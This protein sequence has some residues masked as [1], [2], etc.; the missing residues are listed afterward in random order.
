MEILIKYAIDSWPGPSKLL[1]LLFLAILTIVLPIGILLW[2]K[3]FIDRD[4]YIFQQSAN[5]LYC[6]DSMTGQ[7]LVA[8]GL[9]FQK[10]YIMEA[11]NQN[12]EEE[13]EI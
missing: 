12:K 3:K 13:S 7:I 2:A 6:L 5:R 1:V 11:K 9:F 8:R 10:V 4:R